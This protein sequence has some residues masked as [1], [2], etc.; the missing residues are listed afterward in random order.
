MRLLRVEVT[1]VFELE[2][3]YENYIVQEYEDDKSMIDHLAEYDFNVLPVLEEGV[4]IVDSY[5]QDV[6]FYELDEF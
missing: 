5:V 6:D 1:K 4:K 3:N 2:V